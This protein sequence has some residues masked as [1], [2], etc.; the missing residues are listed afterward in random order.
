MERQKGNTTP[1]HEHTLLAT[2]KIGT[3]MKE[4][5]SETAKGFRFVGQTVFAKPQLLGGNEY[6]AIMQR[7]LK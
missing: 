3:M 1:T 6:V 4:I 2:T 7:P 5:G